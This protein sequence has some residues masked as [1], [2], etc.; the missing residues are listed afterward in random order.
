MELPT[1]IITHFDFPIVFFF[2]LLCLFVLPKKI[3][4]PGYFPT[5]SRTPLLVVHLPRLGLSLLRRWVLNRNRSPLLSP[6]KKDKLSIGRHKPH[7]S[8]SLLWPVS[9]HCLSRRWLNRPIDRVPLLTVRDE[10]QILSL[11]ITTV[12]LEKY[13]K[14][15]Y[16]LN[17]A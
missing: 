8:H 14:P 3:F 13:E 7:I 2:L 16:E 12:F 4:F 11:L 10:L 6:K 5:L 15:K 1:S 9:E 17:Y